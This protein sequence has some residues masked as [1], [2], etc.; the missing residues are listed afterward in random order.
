[1]K[2]LIPLILPAVLL[3]A[4]GGENSEPLKANPD[5]SDSS[6]NNNSQDTTNQVQS[7]GNDFNAQR[8]LNKFESTAVFWQIEG[9][10]LQSKPQLMIL[11]D[12]FSLNASHEL[13]SDDTLCLLAAN[14]FGSSSAQTWTG[15]DNGS[16][17]QGELYYYSPAITFTGALPEFTSLDN[18]RSQGAPAQTPIA[19]PS[20]EIAIWY[21]TRDENRFTLGSPQSNQNPVIL[22]C[23]QGGFAL[24]Y[25][26]SQ[27]A[28]N[29][30]DT[31]NPSFC[32]TQGVGDSAVTQCLSV[33]LTTT[34][35]LAS[36]QFGTT[37]VALPDSSGNKTAVKV[38][39][40]LDIAVNEAELN[41]TQID[42]R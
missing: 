8:S 26:L 30:R 41:I 37:S 6:T 4:C 38:S 14:I 25:S 1:M 19:T 11:A 29:Q 28:Q 5:P 39:G 13:S 33:A 32:E 17:K 21:R 2:H 31:L 36:C 16:V 3:A 12:K 22:D 34:D 10:R 24:S 20:S 15:D 40:A 7:C 18:W 9:D 23:D 35:K 27:V 42:I